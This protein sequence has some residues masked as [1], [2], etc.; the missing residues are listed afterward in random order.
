MLGP[1]SD[2]PAPDV[3]TNEQVMAWIMDTYSMH[4]RHTVTAVVTGKPVEMGGSLGR[5]EA[6][7]RG[8]HD[9][10]QGSAARS[11]ACRCTARRWR[12]R[13]SATSARSPRSCSSSEGLQDR[14]DQRQDG[15]HLQPERHRR[16]RGDRVDRARTA[17]RGLPEGRADH[18]TSEL[19]ELD[20]DVLVPAALE[21]VITSKNAPKIKAQDHLRGRE[22]PDD[23]AAPTRFSTRR[24]SS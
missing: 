10:R 3:N 19:L 21:N 12:C 6:T 7:G 20:V 23:R 22:R 17:P 9:R 18:A 14:R 11:S 8:V 13:A 15:R 2:V 24:G 1:E 4:M 5:R 16:R